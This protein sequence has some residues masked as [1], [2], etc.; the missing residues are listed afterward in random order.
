MVADLPPSMQLH[1]YICAAG[2][3]S[4]LHFFFFAL[5]A[6]ESGRTLCRPHSPS[7]GARGGRARKAQHPLTSPRPARACLPT[8][9]A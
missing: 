8:T 2:H 4:F 9:L 1:P 6:Y 3:S 5:L 7:R